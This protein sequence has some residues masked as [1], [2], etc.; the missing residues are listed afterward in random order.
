[1]KEYGSLKGTELCQNNFIEVVFMGVSE[2]SIS[3]LDNS[4]SGSSKWSI[5]LRFPHQ[6]RVYASP[7]PHTCYITSPYVSF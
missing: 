6:N 3:V 4:T 7:L 5:S 2:F 1:M